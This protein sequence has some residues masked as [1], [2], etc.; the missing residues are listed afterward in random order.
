MRSKSDKIAPT[1]FGGSAPPLDWIEAVASEFHSREVSPGPGH[2]ERHA[3]HRHSEAILKLA[4]KEK[5]SGNLSLSAACKRIECESDSSEKPQDRSDGGD[6]RDH[7]GD[8]SD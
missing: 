4:V 8:N 2:A 3:W 1:Y 7:G 5:M 6:Y